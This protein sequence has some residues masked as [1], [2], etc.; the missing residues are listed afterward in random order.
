M[1]YENRFLGTFQGH[2]K[3]PIN[4]EVE[5]ARSYNL[6]RQEVARG[7]GQNFPKGIKIFPMTS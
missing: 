7:L 5:F 6:G 3:R 1:H 2:S 4:K